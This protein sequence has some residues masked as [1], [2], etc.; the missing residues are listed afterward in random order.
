MQKTK[1]KNV[2]GSFNIPGMALVAGNFRESSTGSFGVLKWSVLIPSCVSLSPATPASSC[3]DL[4]TIP[5][6]WLKVILVDPFYRSYMLDSS[7]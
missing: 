4:R 7:S 1:Q 5:T 2:S 3:Q 6:L